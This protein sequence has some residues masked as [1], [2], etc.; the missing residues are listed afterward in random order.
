MKIIIELLND[1]KK[2]ML[3][4]AVL[5]IIFIIIMAL[6]MMKNKNEE[7]IPENTQ[8]EKIE[9]TSEIEEELTKK[10]KELKNAYYCDI[11]TTTEKYRNDCIYRKEK[12]TVEEL[13]EE[14]RIYSLVLAMNNAMEKKTNYIVGNIIVDNFKFNNT[15]FIDYEVLKQ[16]YLSIYGENSTFNPLMVNDMNIFPYMKYDESRKKMLYQTTGGTTSENTKNE[17]I[18]YI[19]DFESDETNVYVYVSIA[20]VVPLNS[21]TYEVYKDKERTSLVKKITS[22]SW[23]EGNIITTKDF[24]IYQ[25]FKFT[26]AKEETTGSLLFKQVE[27]ET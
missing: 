13:S 25:E 4:I 18:D 14:Y 19:N 10:I 22:E 27:A 12:T 16:E 6:S 20:Y 17:L 7:P 11:Q 5:V 26:F 1:K 3:I 21:T 24:S 23:N 8:P 2:K 9:I 15:Q